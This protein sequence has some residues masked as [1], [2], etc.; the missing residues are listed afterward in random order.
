[1]LKVNLIAHNER[2]LVEVGSCVI[3]LSGLQFWPVAVDLPALTSDTG[4][5]WFHGEHH[6]ESTGNEFSGC[7]IVPKRHLLGA[8]SRARHHP[9]DRAMDPFNDGVAL[10]AIRAAKVG[11]DVPTPPAAGAPRRCER[12]LRC[13]KVE[14][15]VDP[16]RRICWSSGWPPLLLIHL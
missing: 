3:L 10:A 16:S 1:M 12:L 2:V 4:H 5:F 9:F 13:L 11:C 14:T 7:C 8:A 15:L 6:L